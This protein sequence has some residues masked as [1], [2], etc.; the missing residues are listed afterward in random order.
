MIG[1]WVVFH[2]KNET[3]PSDLKD[4][5]AAQNGHILGMVIGFRYAKS[6]ENK[7]SNPKTRQ[8]ITLFP[9]QVT[10]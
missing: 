10:Q 9:Y 8:Y 4:E 2:L 5:I 1:D 3:I 7:Q 6:G